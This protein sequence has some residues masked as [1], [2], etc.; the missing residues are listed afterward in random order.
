MEINEEQ[1]E[2][3]KGFS[4]GYA[5]GVLAFVYESREVLDSIEKSITEE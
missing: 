4:D 1:T 3:N 5:S 2:Y